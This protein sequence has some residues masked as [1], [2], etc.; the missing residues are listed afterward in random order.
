MEDGD[1]YVSEGVI[2]KLPTGKFFTY[3]VKCRGWS[4]HGIM[5]TTW[6]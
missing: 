2:G 6:I 4:H 5:S 3:V 1:K